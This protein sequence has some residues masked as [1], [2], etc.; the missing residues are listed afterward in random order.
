MKA[1]KDFYRSLYRQV[2]NQAS[3]SKPTNQS[4]LGN[5]IS[6]NLPPKPLPLKASRAKP[7]VKTSMEVTFEGEQLE[8][9]GLMGHGNSNSHMSDESDGESKLSMY[10]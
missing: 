7:S 8:M 1:E 9:F 2:R 5:S 10:I 4:L 3:E 6:G